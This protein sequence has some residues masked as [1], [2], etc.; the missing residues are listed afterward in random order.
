MAMCRVTKKAFM[1][2]HHVSHSNIKTKRR[3]KVNVQKKRIYDIET[4][5]FVRV[6]LSTRALR[7][8]HKKSIASLLRQAAKA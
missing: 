2:G 1:C 4:G 3:Q 8:A 5:R 6:R 7:T